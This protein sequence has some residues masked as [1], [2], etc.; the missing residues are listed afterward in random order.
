MRPG[1]ST[2]DPTRAPN[3]GR[4]LVGIAAAVCLGLLLAGCQG[5]AGVGGSKRSEKNFCSELKAGNA[6][7]KAHYAAAGQ[8]VPSQLGLI[9]QEVGEYTRL[10]HRLDEAAPDEIKTEMHDSREAWDKQADNISTS[11]PLGMLA[12]GLMNAMMSS[13]SM[14]AVD[15]YAKSH[16]DVYVF[17]MG[18][19]QAKQTAGPDESCPDVGFNGSFDPTDTDMSYDDF[20]SGLESLSSSTDDDVSSAASL[21]LAATEELD[22]APS[23]ATEALG[24]LAFENVDATTQLLTDLNSAVD[25][26]CQGNIVNSS[27]VEELPTTMTP[28][29]DG[30]NLVVGSAYGR[31]PTE[32]GWS[33][34]QEVLWCDDGTIELLEASTGVSTS[35]TLSG[36]QPSPT[37]EETDPDSVYDGGADDSGESEEPA[38]YPQPFLALDG[39][40]WASQE[41]TPAQGLRDPE[42]IE[43]LNFADLET[44]AAVFSVQTGNGPQAGD[45]QAIWTGTGDAII[46]V[47]DNQVKGYGSDGKTSWVH[48]TE[49]DTD[50]ASTPTTD[51]FVL[52]LGDVVSS[53]TGTVLAPGS[54]SADEEGFDACGETISGE[55]AI[56]VDPIDGPPHVVKGSGPANTL[57]D[58]VNTTAADMYLG[59]ALNDGLTGWTATGKKM[60]SLSAN[61]V[62]DYWVLGRWV[63]VTNTAG[64]TV[65]VD[66]HTGA[67]VTAQQ[68]DVASLAQAGADAGGPPE[69]SVG[70][71]DGSRMFAFPDPDDS[72]SHVMISAPA[73]VCDLS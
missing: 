43:R 61:V 53:A 27:W 70:I 16:C 24:R 4:L 60:W 71:D 38:E 50:I 15:K 36:M 54:G 32:L 59:S 51:T 62:D 48:K 20:R 10:V 23:W 39:I 72:A 64:E 11:D 41:F 52:N 68:S 37:D 31:C 13:A 1:T 65:V 47:F 44:G 7:M 40:A 33:G 28:R 46:G 8:D 18:T 57:D 9:A 3:H 6:R 14:A 42:W 63:I 29:R 55:R 58:S 22:P 45:E 2:G 25:Q 21:V 19:P 26:L 34:D 12:S 30:N 17:S 73:S 66:A 5:V 49:Y 35:V 69:F 56:V 67:D